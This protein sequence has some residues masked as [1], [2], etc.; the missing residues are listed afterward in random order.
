LFYCGTRI[1][2]ENLEITLTKKELLDKLDHYKKSGCSDKEFSLYRERLLDEYSESL[3]V[4][5]EQKNNDL[6]KL[7]NE[8]KNS[9]D[10]LIDF[11]ISLKSSQSSVYYRILNIVGKDLSYFVDKNWL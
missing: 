6:T 9:I 2:L 4:Q 1:I 5:L 3:E 10:N 7:I 11:A 8:H